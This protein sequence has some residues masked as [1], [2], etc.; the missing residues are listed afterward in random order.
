MKT[1]YFQSRSA[2]K[3][4]LLVLA[5]VAVSLAFVTWYMWGFLEWTTGGILKPRWDDY[6][7]MIAKDALIGLT[8]QQAAKLIEYPADVGQ[9]DDGPHAEFYLDHIGFFTW[10]TADLDEQGRITHAEFVVD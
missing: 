8:P 10:I 1:S 9:S 2:L 3:A 7:A 5:L 4:T 6:E